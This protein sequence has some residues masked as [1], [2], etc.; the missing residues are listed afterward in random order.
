MRQV[1]EEYGNVIKQDGIDDPEFDLFIKEVTTEITAKAGQKCTAVRRILVA[2][3][4]KPAVIDAL[5]TRLAKITLGDPRRD[6][7]AMGAL[8]SAAQKA[9][10]LEKCALFAEEARR[11]IGSDSPT[12]AGDGLEDGAFLGL[13]LRLCVGG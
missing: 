4:M 13:D 9:D 2:D 10:V 11:V 6:D 5:E 3:T 7:V 8:A 12:L 1:W